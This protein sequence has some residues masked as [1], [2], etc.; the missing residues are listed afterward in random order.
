MSVKYKDYPVYSYDEPATYDDFTGGINSDPSNEHLL[1]NELRDCVNM[2]YLSGALVKRK[3]AKKICDIYIG[4]DKQP[5]DNLQGM[6]LFTDNNPNSTVT[7]IIVANDGNLYYGIYKD[8]GDDIVLTKLDIYLKK[9]S[10]NDYNPVYCC[11]DI[12]SGLNDTEIEL[13]KNKYG[14]D[15]RYNNYTVYYDLYK[16]KNFQK[17]KPIEAAT[18]NEQQD[19][20]LNN[21]YIATGTRIV[22]VSITDGKPY[23]EC[24]E[25]Y[26]INGTELT[27]IGYNYLSPYPELCIASQTNTV[28]TSIYGLNVEKLQNNEYRLTP[29]MNI[30]TGD[31]SDNYY[32][33]WEKEI[34]NTWYTVYTFASQFINYTMYWKK[35]DDSKILNSDSWLEQSSEE[36]LLS[37][38][39]NYLK[40][41]HGV[42]KAEVLPDNNLKENYPTLYNKYGPLFS[43]NPNQNFEFFKKYDYVS[44][45]Y[46]N[47]VVLYPSYDSEFYKSDNCT[48]KYFGEYKSIKRVYSYI[49][50]SIRTKNF[51]DIISKETSTT[52]IGI[53]DDRFEILINKFFKNKTWNNVKNI[54]IQNCP[55]EVQSYLYTNYN[56]SENQIT[57]MDQQKYYYYTEISDY[58]AFIYLYTINLVSC[59]SLK[60]QLSSDRMYQAFDTV[61]LDAPT[62]IRKTVVDYNDQSYTLVRYGPNSIVDSISYYSVITP[63]AD[64]TPFDTDTDLDFAKVLS[65]EYLKQTIDSQ[66]IWYYEPYT[67]AEYAISIES[68]DSAKDYLLNSNNLPVI[69]KKDQ[70]SNYF[71]LIANCP[72]DT[73]I[74][75]EDEKKIN[76]L[77][78]TDADKYKYR[79]TFAKS[80]EEY[81]NAPVEWNSTDTNIKSGVYKNYGRNVYVCML[82]HDAI[83]YYTE[84]E[85][86]EDKIT[87]VS[88]V[89]GDKS[90]TTIQNNKDGTQTVTKIVV[91]NAQNTTTTTVT[92]RT[93]SFDVALNKGVWKLVQNYT[94]DT[95]IDLDT[96]NND[97]TN[98]TTNTWDYIVNEVD[99]EYFGQA[100]SVLWDDNNYK[101]TNETFETIQSCTKVLADG[102][103]LLFYGDKYNS[104]WWFKTIISNPAYIT[105]KGCLSF[106]TTK[107][108]ELKKIVPFQGNIIAF[109][110][111]DTAGGSIHVVSGNGDD[112]DSGDGYY[113]PYQ[114]K[115][116]NSAISCSNEKTIQVC[117]NLLFF[118]YFSRVY[119]ISAS[120]LSND[121]INLYPCNER[122]KTNRDEYSI[123]YESN[124]HDTNIPWDD[125]DCVSESTDQYYGIM[126]KAKYSMD[127]N[128]I[129]YEKHPAMRAKLYYNMSNRLADNTYAY[130]WL[131]DIGNIFNVNNIIYIKGN[132][133]YYYNNAFIGMY[134]DYYKDLDADIPCKIQLRGVDLNYPKLYKLISNVIL[135]YHRNQYDNLE[136]TTSLKNEAGYKI[137]ENEDNR[138]SKG[139]LRSL[140]IQA[141]P[142][143][144]ASN[145]TFKVGAV[146]VADTRVINPSY[147][148][149]CMLVDT[150]IE[151]KCDGMFSLSSVTFNYTTI[152]APDTTPMNLY[153][154]I[155][156][157]KEL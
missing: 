151:A 137:L 147:K 100:T 10:K 152:D 86:E 84:K 83:D 74:K 6:F 154:Q 108:E 107:N 141:N 81:P 124:S 44:E 50:D 32:Y 37:N 156:R 29:L 15:S 96:T 94:E 99:G 106:K 93:P 39:Q 25:P 9:L 45:K 102:N 38:I 36:N 57:K 75:L 52:I 130:P 97:L 46:E 122:V 113:S 90:K 138:K 1:E 7:Y 131:K 105:S 85:E 132:P 116:V 109:A 155:I 133:I 126:W 115:T 150:T 80:F 19:S 69:V 89:E 8:N 17:D 41:Q 125:D 11:Y 134:E 82:T 23:A 65:D 136:I 60:L 144:L 31:S 18:I 24:V 127:E 88:K 47:E 64:N 35:I 16:L 13:V 129:R 21:L 157:P 110:N 28:S 148:F 153:S 54:I 98:K 68:F 143:Q 5:L 117:D 121:V 71:E 49:C 59:G 61:V 56:I 135:Y 112:Y 140:K 146:S 77:I 26:I 20:Q 34:G 118:K 3:G 139:D 104:G 111:N 87:T 149:P 114:R 22:K 145:D 12:S 42:Y 4:T 95:M 128:G 48:T 73:I 43:T 14:S 123:S 53:D 120:D 33:K 62:S 70:T 67:T 66:T 30:Q 27:K 79:V 51:Y 119:C 40:G 92:T 2:T 55:Y 76:K 142:L 72:A 58:I 103:K 91:N 78:V 101:T 63:D